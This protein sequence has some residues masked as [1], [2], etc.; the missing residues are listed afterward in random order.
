MT[1]TMRVKSPQ[2]ALPVSYKHRMNRQT[3]V[4][5]NIANFGTSSCDTPPPPSRPHLVRILSLSLFLVLIIGVELSF[6]V[7]TKIYKRRGRLTKVHNTFTGAVRI[8]Q[9]YSHYAQN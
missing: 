7:A 3:L 5:K 9:L 2:V 6:L 1:P 4:A 8:P